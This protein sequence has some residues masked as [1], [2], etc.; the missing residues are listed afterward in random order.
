MLS[1][2]LVMSLTD[3]ASALNICFGQTGLFPPF[4]RPTVAPPT[5]LDVSREGDALQEMTALLIL[6]RRECVM[7]VANTIIHHVQNDHYREEYVGQI[8]YHIRDV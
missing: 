4:T 3:P 1:T 2:I 5:L 6:D 8:G 7:R